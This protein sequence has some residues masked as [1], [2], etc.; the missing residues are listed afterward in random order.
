MC[1]HAKYIISLKFDYSGNNIHAQRFQTSYIII[2]F[3]FFH[4]WYNLGAV[5]KDK[6][7][8][9]FYYS[10]L[11]HFQKGIVLFLISALFSSV[12]IKLIFWSIRSENNYIKLLFAGIIFVYVYLIL[13]TIALLQIIHG[14][15]LF[16]AHASIPFH[17]CNC[18]IFVIITMNL[19]PFTTSFHFFLW[20][21]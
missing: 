5:N 16:Y 8:F 10:G 9:R 21:Q 6:Y 18:S 14:L 11:S 19:N 20:P 12:F 15:T 13:T 7:L 1:H 3:W 17:F 4:V 2:L